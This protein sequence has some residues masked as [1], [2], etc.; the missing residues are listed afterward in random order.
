MHPWVNTSLST[1]LVHLLLT[2]SCFSAWLLLIFLS[3]KSNSSRSFHENNFVTS[4]TNSN[5]LART[6]F[7]KFKFEERKLIEI[8]DFDLR[9]FIFITNKSNKTLIYIS[10]IY[11][12]TIADL[13]AEPP[14]KFHTLCIST[15]CIH[16][17]KIL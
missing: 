7:A 16:S 2:L 12:L 11:F 9:I 8:L 3:N 6:Y 15:S 14:L 17:N 10:T 1:V 13:R 4:K 5:R